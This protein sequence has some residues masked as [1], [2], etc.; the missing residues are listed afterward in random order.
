MIG[1]VDI[2]VGNIG[3]LKHA[4]YNLGFDYLLI[5]RG[6]DISTDQISHL[7]L[8]GVGA[9]ADVMSRVRKNG[10]EQFLESYV[11]ERKPLLGICVGMQILGLSGSEPIATKGLCF[12]DG[13]V[14]KMIETHNFRVPHMGWN[15]LQFQV[16]H[17]LLDGV[18]L[19]VD[20]YFVHSYFYSDINKSQVLAT[21]SHGL[22]EIPAIIAKDN[23]AGVQFHPEK[24]QKNG[25]KILENFCNWDTQC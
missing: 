21:A 18:K 10:F 22:N 19:N 9:Y 17:P 13:H 12:V 20:F 24:S 4:V 8:P 6:D 7:I 25:L 16:S 15:E 2:G 1:I 5:S 11:S 3:S 23:V 14:S